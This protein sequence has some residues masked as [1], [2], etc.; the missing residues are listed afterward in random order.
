MIGGLSFLTVEMYSYLAEGRDW[1]KAIQAAID[2][3]HQNYL[4][5]SGPTNILIGGEL[6]VTLNPDST[7]IPGE[8]AAGRGALCMRSGVTLMGGGTITLDG[9]FTGSSSGAIITN[10]EGAADNCKIQGLRLTVAV[11]PLPERESP[12]LISWTRTTSPL[13]T[14]RRLTVHRAAFI[15]GVQIMQFTGVLIL[16]Y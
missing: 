5:G 16:G 12:V 6:T 8:V 10:W 3:A 1:R 11:V 2:K 14:L 13:I 7:L 9:S 4:A 15:C